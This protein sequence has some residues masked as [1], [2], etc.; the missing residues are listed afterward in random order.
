[1]FA[2]WIKSWRDL[3]LK[4]NQWAN[5]VRWEMRT[6]PF[7][8]SAEFLWQEGHTAHETL[9]E[10]IEMSRLALSDYKSIYQDYLAIPVIDGVKSESERFAGAE[11]T[12]TIEGIMRDGKALQM[13]TSHVLLQSFPAS[14]DVR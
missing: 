2:K 1:M 10:A 5:V 4:V 8:R 13:C 9:E 6:R 11:R 14:F 12:Y 7:I 3:P